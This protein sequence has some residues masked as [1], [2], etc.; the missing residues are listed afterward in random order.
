M[1]YFVIIVTISRTKTYRIYLNGSTITE[2]PERTGG[3]EIAFMRTPAV[4][5]GTSYKGERDEKDKNKYRLKSRIRLTL[6]IKQVTISSSEMICDK[7]IAHT[8][9]GKTTANILLRGPPGEAYLAIHIPETIYY[10]EMNYLDIF[11]PGKSRGDFTPPE[12][13]MDPHYL[14]LA[15]E[16]TWE[17]LLETWCDCSPTL[18]STRRSATAI[19]P[20]WGCKTIR[21]KGRMIA[22]RWAN[23]A[24]PCN[25]LSEAEKGYW[26]VLDQPCTCSKWISRVLRQK[27]HYPGTC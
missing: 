23:R 7:T 25:F 16:T 2:T 3:L 14:T 20:I 4:D 24:L 13:M 17:C 10:L 8:E 5:W 21:H 18:Q 22:K 15:P 6:W 12:L 9:T 1:D 26:K 19:R 11:G 27:L